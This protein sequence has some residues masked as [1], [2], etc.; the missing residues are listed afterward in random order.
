MTTNLI[1]KDSTTSLAFSECSLNDNDA[2]DLLCRKA[3]KSDY[4]RNS[5]AALIPEALKYAQGLPIA[6]TVLG[7]FLCNRDIL[8]WRAT[9]DG[10]ENNPD[11]RIMKVLHMSFEG[12][13]PREREIF[14]HVAC[15]FEGE[16]KDY[17][18]R[19]L[20]A[21]G[22]QPDIG[23]P[24]IA[25]KSLITIR[26]QMICMHK[27]LLELGKQIVQGQHLDEPRF[28]S[29]LWLCRDFCHVMM[30]RTE[31]I[32]T[33]AIVLDQK[34]DGFKFNKLQVEGLSKMEHLKLLILNHKDFS[35]KPTSLSNFLYYFSW[36]GYPFTTLPSNFQP[37][38][39]VELNMPDSNITIMGRHPVS[40]LFEKDGS[41]QL[42]KSEDD[43]ML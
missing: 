18:R 2:H 10:L 34:D 26:S 24:L 16:R 9:L 20:H 33:K 29:R 39:L 5:F 13:Q 38:D 1:Y 43:S 21:C 17:V 4:S 30:T 31:A 27:M 22:L 41:E 19:I 7:S 14:L 11:K 40:T 3:F 28:W 42:Q 12:L 23:I 35:G 37:Y 36:N 15:F 8:Q 25:E 6:I 32:E